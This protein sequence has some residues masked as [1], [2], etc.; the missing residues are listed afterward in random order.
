MAG[1]KRLGELYRTMPFHGEAMNGGRGGNRY[2][3]GRLG[4][5]DNFYQISS[6]PPRAG[7]RRSATHVVWT[8]PAYIFSFPLRLSRA[9][10][11][12]APLGLGD[13]TP[14]ATAQSSARRSS[15]RHALASCRAERPCPT[16]APPHQTSFR[17]RA[18]P[19]GT[20]PEAT[21]ARPR[22][23]ARSSFGEFEAGR[24]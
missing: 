13:A 12:G 4:K 16:A 14:H 17:L 23:P 1:S 5:T 11:Q 10:P 2:R 9:P 22:A 21:R 24:G 15:Q 6:G 7:P 8:K 3:R 19:T 18:L 20:L